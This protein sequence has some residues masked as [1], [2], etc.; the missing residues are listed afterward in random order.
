MQMFGLVSL[1]IVVALAAWWLV[2]MGP[3]SVPE[4]GSDAPMYD[5]GSAEAVE[6]YDGVS[7][8]VD[9]KTLNL[10]GRDLTGSLKAEIRLLSELETLDV[11][12]NSFTGL[13]AEVGQLTQLRMLKLADNPLTG[14]PHEL[15]NLQNLVV[16]DLRGTDA[17]EADLAIISDRLPDSTSILTGR[18]PE[19]TA[20]PTRPSY[21]EALDGARGAADTIGD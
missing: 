6:V 20:Q 5:G 10:S 15:G 1:M 2:S 18:V 3:V 17:S 4:Q 16:L 14:L 7:V 13:P 9:T 11:S 21:G 8:P 19:P 12:G